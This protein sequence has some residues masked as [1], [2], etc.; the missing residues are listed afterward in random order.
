MHS[1]VLVAFRQSWRIRV[2]INNACLTQRAFTQEAQAGVQITVNR[3]GERGGGVSNRLTGKQ[4]A[5]SC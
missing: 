3:T 4:V 5:L 1:L 2:F